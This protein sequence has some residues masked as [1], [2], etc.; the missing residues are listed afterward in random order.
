[1]KGFVCD[2]LFAFVTEDDEGNE[3]IVMATMDGNNIPLV[4][5]GL[6]QVKTYIPL[7]SNIAKHNKINI[8]LYHYKRIGEVAEDWT[9]QFIGVRLAGNPEERH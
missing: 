8:K 5:A 9:N 4:T 3:G 2:E 7:A 1:M 6:E